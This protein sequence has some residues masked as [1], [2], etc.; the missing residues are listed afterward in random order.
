MSYGFEDTLYYKVETPNPEFY[1]LDSNVI[2]ILDPGNRVPV[3]RNIQMKYQGDLY[4]IDHQTAQP[5]PI[6]ASV[7]RYIEEY[8][9]KHPGTLQAGNEQLNVRE[10]ITT[11]DG[12]LDLYGIDKLL[13]LNF[14]SH[15]ITAEMPQEWWPEYRK[16][17]KPFTEFLG[18]YKQWISLS[19]DMW[20]EYYKSKNKNL[21]IEISE[22]QKV[23]G[24]SKSMRKRQK[25][26]I[27]IEGTSPVRLKET[28]FGVTS[29]LRV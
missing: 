22:K 4:Y 21:P 26:L 11:K 10:L 3:L 16:D 2:P 17:E 18:I 8:K 5:E 25:A 1:R 9:N 23:G 27:I 14:T 7:K 15:P 13:K 6:S 28:P 12:L 20:S 24:I 19:K 29:Y